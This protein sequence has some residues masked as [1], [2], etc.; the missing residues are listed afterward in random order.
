MTGKYAFNQWSC[1]LHR[2]A[3]QMAQDQT[4]AGSFSQL[5]LPCAVVWGLVGV[6]LEMVDWEERLGVDRVEGGGEWEIWV[7]KITLFYFSRFQKVAGRFCAYVSV[8]TIPCSLK[9][10]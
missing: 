10:L 8:Y 1:E 9:L 4:L 2:N 7:C 3:T 6:K 5:Q